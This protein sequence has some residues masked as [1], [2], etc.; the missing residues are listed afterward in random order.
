MAELK[1]CWTST[2]AASDFAAGQ[3][4]LHLSA[5]PPPF[6]LAGTYVAKDE[7]KKPA[8]ETVLR[9][10][11]A[12]GVD[13]RGFSRAS[14]SAFITFRSNLN[15][16][17][18]TI[19]DLKTGWTVDACV[20]PSCPTLCLLD[21]VKPAPSEWAASEESRRLASFGYLFEA[22]CT[23]AAVADANSET[24]VLVSTRVGRHAVLLGAE[25]DACAGSQLSL[26]GLR[27]LKT[28]K[29]PAHRGQ[30]RTLYKIKHAK[31]WLQSHLAGVPELLL[32]V[33]DDAGVVS[34]L[35]AVRTA[36]LPRISTHNGEQ[37]SPQQ[38]LAFAD[39]VLA[40]L[41][42]AARRQAGSHMRFVYDPANALI[43]SA[44]L[45]GGD[46]PARMEGFFAA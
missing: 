11:R 20:L 9:A 17:I 42:A 32:G 30:H 24:S 35:H 38:M 5:P 44:V 39:D 12:A 8:V 18:G 45:E 29:L 37:W 16:L 25:V 15:K 10:A 4:P 6:A 36:E 46:L 2:T 22:R 21:I 28:L 31:W 23:G 26:A 14:T 27:E 13:V 41:H 7:A 34:A 1:W 33:R 19:V 43:S 3:T 40:W